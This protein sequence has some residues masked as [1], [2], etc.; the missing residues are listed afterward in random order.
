[1]D[2]VLV[3]QMRR[4]WPLV[5]ASAVFVVFMVAHQALFQP[6]AR[7]YE[8]ALARAHDL[9]LAVDPV[10]MEPVMP[11][12]LYARVT[13]NSMTPA[14]AVEQASS[15]VLSARLLEE[16]AQSAS[17]AG[18]DVLMSEPGPASQASTSTLLRAHVTL[19]GHYSDYVTFLD[20][21]SR[22]RHLLAVDRFSIRPQDGVLSIEIWMSRL[23]L[24]REGAHE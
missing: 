8:T 17:G 19:R 21:M 11:P 22:S 9:G 6:A 18:L 16:I 24:K 1:M 14:A 20:L 10:A 12:R 7:R 2:P 5:V 15:G 4:Q 3:A 13:D 23:V